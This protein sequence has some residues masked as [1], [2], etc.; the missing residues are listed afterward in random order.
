MMESIN[1]IMD[2][3]QYEVVNQEEGDFVILEKHV[4]RNV[5]DKNINIIRP[6][7]NDNIEIYEVSDPKIKGPSTR[8]QKNNHIENIF[9]Y[10]N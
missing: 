1:V 5:P 10:L 6:T 3:I 7:I 9:G 2:D 8:V 4:L